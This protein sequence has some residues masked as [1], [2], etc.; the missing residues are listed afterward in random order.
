MKRTIRL[1]LILIV[2][3]NPLVAQ[4]IQGPFPPPQAGMVKQPPHASRNSNN[5]S[6]DAPFASA[7]RNGVRAQI[8]PS[9]LSGSGISLFEN[10]STAKTDGLQQTDIL[11]VIVQFRAQPIAA[12]GN[13]RKG[14]KTE[15]LRSTLA[16]I[17]SEHA[18][19]RSDIA[20]L[21]SSRL[22]QALSAQGTVMTHI[23]FEYNVA[24]NGMALTTNRGAL[25]EI[26]NLPYV[27]RVAQ[28]QVVRVV[29]DASNTVIGAPAFW[30][31]TGMHGEGIDIGLIDTG[32]DYLHE[33]LGGAPF[34]NSKVVGGYDCAN[35]D[36]DPMDDYGHGTHVAGIIAG[37]GPPP[38]NLRG[39]AYKAHLWVY[40][41][42]D[43]TGT[44]YYSWILAA[45]ERVLDPDANPA[46]PT[47]IS[48]VNMSFG[49]TGTPDDPISE[50]VDNLV[51]A[52]VVAAVAAGNDGDQL[53]ISSPGCA[54]K[55]LTV[56]ATSITD[57]VTSWSSR[58]PTATPFLL[59]PDVVA[60]GLDILSAKMGGGYVLMSGTSMATPHVTGAAA[61]VR[62]RHPDWTPEMIKTAFM[63]SARDLGYDPWTQG[64]GRISIPDADRKSFL[65]TPPSVNFGI[66]TLVGGSW[67]ISDTLSIHNLDAEIK[68]FNISVAFSAMPGVKLTPDPSQVTVAAGSTQHVVVTL[69]VDNDKLPYADVKKYIGKI[70]A[71]SSANDSVDIPFAFVKTIYLKLVMDESPWWITL[72]NGPY[73]ED[74]HAIFIGFHGPFTWTWFLNGGTRELIGMFNDGKTMFHRYP[75]NQDK[76]MTIYINKSESKNKIVFRGLDETGHEV[77]LTQGNWRYE[78]AT[79]E[80]LGHWDYDPFCPYFFGCD[81]TVPRDTINFPDLDSLYN[82]DV[83]FL[84]FYHGNYY[85]FPF[86]LDHGIFSPATLTCDQSNSVRTD[87]KAVAP[88][89][90]DSLYV[91]PFIG[92]ANEVEIPAA[93]LTAPFRWSAYSH[94]TTILPSWMKYTNYRVCSGPDVFEPPYGMFVSTLY[95]SAVTQILPRDTVRFYRWNWEGY[96]NLMHSSTIPQT[97]IGI[98]YGPLRWSG[99]TGNLPTTIQVGM[100]Y[101]K[102][103]QGQL[104]EFPYELDNAFRYQLWVGRT[105]IDEDWMRQGDYSIQQCWYKR[106]VTPGFYTFVAQCDKYKVGDLPGM[107][108]ASLTFDTRRLDPNPPSLTSLHLDTREKLTDE[109]TYGDSAR[110]VFD[111]ADESRIDSVG[112]FFQPLGAPNWMNERVL[113]SGNHCTFD[114]ESSPSIGDGYYSLRLIVVD[115]ARNTLDYKVEPAF[116]YHKA[117]PPVPLLV[118]PIDNVQDRPDRLV[119]SWSQSPRTN[120][121]HLQLARDNGFTTLVIDD[122]TL[123]GT[124]LKIGPLNRGTSYYW[125]VSARNILGPSAYSSTRTFTISPDSTYLYPVKK[126]W[127]LLSLPLLAVNKATRDIYPS[128]VSDAFGFDGLSY[129]VRDTVRR[130]MGYWLRFGV[131]DTIP[132]PGKVILSDT[133]HVVR[134]WNLIGSVSVPVNP[135]SVQSLPPG[136]VTSSFWGYATGYERVSVFAPGEGYWVKCSA[137]GILYLTASGPLSRDA[138]RD[139]VSGSPG[140]FNQLTILD[141][142]GNKQTLYYGQ[143]SGGEISLKMYEL[144]PAPP[145]GSFD[146]RFSSQRILEMIQPGET[147]SFKI[148]VVSDNYPLTVMWQQIQQYTG[149]SLS[150][151]GHLYPLSGTGDVRI[152]NP[153]STVTLIVSGGGPLPRSYSLSQCYP[154][155]FNPTTTIRYELPAHSHVSLKVYNLLG[156]VVEILVD[157]LQDAGY[158]Q[159]VWNAGNS[160][161]GVYFCRLEAVSVVDPDKNFTG[162]KKLLL[163]R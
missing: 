110:I 78:F 115:S 33:A 20:R 105:L 90:E 134:G 10:D 111:V 83:N 114:I 37:E 5:T 97:E 162:V 95:S 46:T 87:Y 160:A 151:G 124:S 13:L 45:I 39:V 70:I 51:S 26:E 7:P 148:I 53:P 113:R 36:P 79:Y 66:D 3:A 91:Y 56:G 145:A 19:F 84:T 103:F 71:R 47:P 30:D 112:F 146:A 50:A 68:I 138:S 69:M 29:D 94:P 93:K 123:A 147:K 60:P 122:S 81:P 48:V 82:F 142:R 144:P 4:W 154:D 157:A 49:G 119:L 75:F 126:D 131:I 106:D 85:E 130:N 74:W 159:V 125:R 77:P 101:D 1:F 143:T 121:Y 132:I 25:D 120:S 6:G 107:A 80:I 62:Q 34:P 44:G 89:N 18:Q 156:Q 163:L 99:R 153:A 27:L 52:G 24:F 65:V 67:K 63:Q 118:S 140:A 14:L 21:N 149:T 40:K 133:F 137:D 88:Q 8:R 109:I 152:S 116:L 135:V 100:S 58:G 139:D 23:R 96:S 136:I 32:I 73:G 57:S 92:F 38:T 11:K 2:I 59:K 117:P 104:W 76:P 155:P 129:Y 43:A 108:S 9:S 128:S 64:A 31:S 42:F 35:D 54:R 150:V 28:D 17:Q 158:K 161:S 141:A 41:A 55:A 98:G 15:Q 12:C 86:T 127:N 16:A 102:I 61:L 72:A 22:Q